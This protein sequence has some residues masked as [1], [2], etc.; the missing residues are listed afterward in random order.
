MTLRK[1][2]HFA[3]PW[4]YQGGEAHSH[5]TACMVKVRIGPKGGAKFLVKG[6]W[7]KKAA[8]TPGTKWEKIFES[9]EK[10]S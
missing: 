10:P 5:C 6:Q 7:V 8:C 4:T 9:G 1:K 2:H 3:T